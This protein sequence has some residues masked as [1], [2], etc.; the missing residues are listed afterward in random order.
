[1]RK[2]DAK[3]A[4]VVVN[5][6]CMWGIFF[7]FAARD[8]LLHPPLSSWYFPTILEIISRLV[9]F[10]CIREYYPKQAFGKTTIGLFVIA[11]IFFALLALGWEYKA[12]ILVLLSLGAL[13]FL[14]ESF[15]IILGMKQRNV[16]C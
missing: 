16:E 11:R 1:M 2:C 6:L 13:F 7:W 8:T 15:W 12:G 4:A 9:T 10:S 5:L 3:S 14:A